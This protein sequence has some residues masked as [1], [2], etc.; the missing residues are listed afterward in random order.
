[1][2]GYQEINGKLH[3]DNVPLSTIAQTYGTPAYVYSADVIKSQYDALKN[4]MVKALPSDRQPMLCYAC[5]AN[6]N[7]GILA[8]LKSLGASLEIVSEGELHRGLKA[9]FEANEIVATGVGKTDNE[10]RECLK[11]GIHQFNIES[12]R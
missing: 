12:Q 5:K 6:S 9:G 8:Y 1:M 4:A 11:A 3:V 7:I 2:T 10:I